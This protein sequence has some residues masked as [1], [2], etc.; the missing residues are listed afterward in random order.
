MLQPG[1]SLWPYTVTTKNFNNY[2]NHTQRTSESTQEKL[3]KNVADGKLNTKQALF[4]M[5]K[6]GTVVSGTSRTSSL[7]QNNMKARN[8]KQKLRPN[9][10][11][12][13]KWC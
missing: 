11:L 3:A 9:N 1:N 5:V 6:E 7:P 8:L 13:N 10:Q 2:G 12:N 4:K